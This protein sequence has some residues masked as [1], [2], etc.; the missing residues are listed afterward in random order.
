M[1]KFVFKRFALL[2][3]VFMVVTSTSLVASNTIE[4]TDELSLVSLAVD[5]DFDSDG[6]VDPKGKL[7]C[8]DCSLHT[9][10]CACCGA[11]GGESGWITFQWCD[12][13]TSG[14]KATWELQADEF[15]SQRC[16]DGPAGG[17]GEGGPE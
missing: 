4:P 12:C 16:G 9:V 6:V 13:L 1:M 15:C 3:V 17:G 7:A 14:Y 8:G 2:A 5:L 11:C 10:Y